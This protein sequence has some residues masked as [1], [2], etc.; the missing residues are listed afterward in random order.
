MSRCNSFQKI[1][2]TL[3]VIHLFPAIFRFGNHQL[4]LLGILYS[5]NLNFLHTFAV[6]YS[7]EG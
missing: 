4:T 6:P 2:Q 5:G 1:Y 3:Q 7:L